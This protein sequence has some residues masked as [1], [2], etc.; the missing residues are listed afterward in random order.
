MKRKI[1]ER[2]E[3]RFIFSRIKSVTV[4][5]SLQFSPA[6]TFN[7]SSMKLKTL[8]VFRTSSLRQEPR[9]FVFS[10]NDELYN[11]EDNLVACIADGLHSDEITILS[12]A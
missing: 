10:I 8:R 1:R 5:Q 12:S 11:L 2:S 7:K 9:N 4:L 6:R 3:I